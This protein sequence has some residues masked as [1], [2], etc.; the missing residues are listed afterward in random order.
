VSDEARARG[1]VKFKTGRGESRAVRVERASHRHST[2]DRSGW[3]PCDQLDMRPFHA[4]G[5]GSTRTG[6]WGD[7]TRGP[8]GVEACRSCPPSITGPAESGCSASPLAGARLPPCV[9]PCLPQRSAR[10]SGSSLA[11]AI[12]SGNLS[13]NQVH[14]GS[15]HR[16]TC[17]SPPDGPVVRGPS[18]HRLSSFP[19][20]SQAHPT[21]GGVTLFGPFPSELAGTP[22]GSVA[23]GN[24]GA[25]RRSKPCRR[26]SMSQRLNANNPRVVSPAMPN[27]RDARFECWGTAL[28]VS[29]GPSPKPRI[30]HGL[31]Q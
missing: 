8:H 22:F 24:N 28:V 23:V 26:R 19:Q 21:T 7:E 2:Y 17:S 4:M 6:D 29:R 3:I 5:K 25:L 1:P 31:G 18:G 16:G 27:A 30:P 14:P 10:A 12:V 9:W 15:A 20:I 13:D 11:T